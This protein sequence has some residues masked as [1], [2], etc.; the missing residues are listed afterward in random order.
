M[1]CLSYVAARKPLY[2]ALAMAI[3]SFGGGMPMV[4]HAG[5]VSSAPASS[6]SP[7]TADNAT[8]DGTKTK[9]P[10]TRPDLG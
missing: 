2:A 6:S 10:M 4:V 7:Q 9:T 5:Q 1:T 8:T 3:L